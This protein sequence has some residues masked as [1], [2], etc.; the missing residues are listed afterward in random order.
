MLGERHA[1]NLWIF[2]IEMCPLQ[3]TQLYESSDGLSVEVLGPTGL[4]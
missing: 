4:G 1:L 3:R 2:K